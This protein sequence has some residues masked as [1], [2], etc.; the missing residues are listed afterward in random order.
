[1]GLLDQLKVLRQ[2]VEEARATDT[3]ADRVPNGSPV[4]A[5][6]KSLARSSVIPSA[7][8]VVGAPHTRL[9]GHTLH[10]DPMSSRPFSY[11]NIFGMISGV[12]RPEQCRTEVNVVDEFTKSI[13]EQYP[14]WN[15]LPGCILIPLSADLIPE[16]T[17]GAIKSMGFVNGS[18]VD[19]DEVNWVRER[20]GQATKAM[21]SQNYNA[22]GSFIPNPAHGDLIRLA[23][24]TPG[25]FS[26]GASTFPIPPSGAIDFPRVKSATEVDFVDG[27]GD[28]VGETELG[29]DAMKLEAKMVSGIVTLSN[30]LMMMSQPAAETIVQEDLILSVLLKLDYYGFFGPGGK[31]P[32]GLINMV[33]DGVTKVVP[34]TVTANGDTLSPSDWFNLFWTPCAQANRQFTGWVMNPRAYATNVTFRADSGFAA[35]DKAGLFMNNL[36][37]PLG[38]PLGRSLEQW[39]GH[40]CT[41][42]NQIPVNRTKGNASNLSA[43]FGGPWNEAVVGLFGAVQ[44]LINP[45]AE[46]AYNTLATKVRVTALGDFNVRYPEAFSFADGISN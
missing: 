22:G 30:K 13:R 25:L 26:A 17:L 36:V 7:D 34:S 39:F 41:W 19:Q 33:P 40:K 37:N 42:T 1:M 45:Y 6:R 3:V 24:N 27:E 32:R 8:S 31:A 16:R 12:L 5:A 38:T 18:N 9:K 21:S 20:T 11:K 14:D 28:E 46:S 10:E 35:G 4:S 44:A 23:R 43:A 2:T 15:P 29:T